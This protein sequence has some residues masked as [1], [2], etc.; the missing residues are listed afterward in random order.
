MYIKNGGAYI[1]DVDGTTVIDSNHRFLG[2]KVIDAGVIGAD[3]SGMSDDANVD[4]THVPTGWSSHSNNV[5][6][7]KQ[8]ITRVTIAPQDDN[9][10]GFQSHQSSTFEFTQ[11]F[12]LFLSGSFKD[13]S[14]NFIGGVLTASDADTV[15]LEIYSLMSIEANNPAN[16]KWAEAQVFWEV[17]EIP[18]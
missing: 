12:T 4:F 16:D 5:P 17:V 8:W 10:P 11:G 2:Y 9:T 18:S 3:N 1:E 7:N 6:P 15:K 13:T 14:D